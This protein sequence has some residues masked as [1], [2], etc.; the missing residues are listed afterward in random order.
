MLTLA[1]EHILVDSDK[2]ILKYLKTV[3]RPLERQSGQNSDIWKTKS[4]HF[5]ITFM[6]HEEVQMKGLGR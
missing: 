6:Y 2:L 5:S 1:S 4:L 3:F